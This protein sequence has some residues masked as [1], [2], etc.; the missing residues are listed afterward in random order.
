MAPPRTL[1]KRK[2]NPPW[3][4][5][6][7][8]Y[9]NGVSMSEI[10]RRAGWSAGQASRRREV[11]DIRLGD[12]HRL[13]TALGVE[14]WRLARAIIDESRYQRPEAAHPPKRTRRASVRSSDSADAR[15][16]DHMAGIR[17]RRTGGLHALKESP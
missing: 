12:V 14:P 10:Y 9:L 3:L 8:R 4:R 7:E 2:W 15:I 17:A 6:A 5:V 11:R 1:S 13:A 16:L